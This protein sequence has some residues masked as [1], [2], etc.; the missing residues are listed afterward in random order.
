MDRRHLKSVR[1]LYSAPRSGLGFDPDIRRDFLDER[2]I[3][4]HQGLDPAEIRRRRAGPRKF[5]ET[6]WSGR[7]RGSVGKRNAR[8]KR[9][10][11]REITC[12]SEY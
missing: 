12:P 1:R 11:P 2:R 10:L 7:C 9:H 4:I 8:G 6:A 3:V 5:A